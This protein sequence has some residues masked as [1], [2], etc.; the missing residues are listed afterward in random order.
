[1]IFDLHN[2]QQNGQLRSHAHP[3]SHLRWELLPDKSDHEASLL[4]MP[5]ETTVETSVGNDEEELQKVSEES[6]DA[7]IASIVTSLED[8]RRSRDQ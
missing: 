2:L 5:D 6:E 7:G 1:M 8:P 4:E 3:G